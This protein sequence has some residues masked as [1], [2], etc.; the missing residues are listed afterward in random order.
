MKKLLIISLAAM[1][2]V[3]AKAELLEPSVA[4]ER[5]LDEMP[6]GSA[7]RAMRAKTFN[8]LKTVALNS[9][10]AELYVFEAPSSLMVVSAESETAALLG[11]SDNY[12]EGCELPP[13]MVTMLNLYAE[14]I[15]ALRQGNVISATA[16]ADSRADF[17]PIDPICKTQWNQNGPYNDNTPSINGKKTYTGCVATAMAQVLKTYEYPA[18]CSGGSYTYAWTKGGKNLTLNFNTVT[19]RWDDMLDSY[20]G[21]STSSQRSAVAGLMKAI[22][23]ASQMDYGSDASG[24]QSIYC[25]AGLIRNFD[26][27]CTSRF[28]QRDW[29][30]LADWQK[31]I[32]DELA[33]GHP[34]YYDGQ[35]ADGNAGHAFVI[36]GYSSDGFFHVNWGWGGSLDGYFLLTALDPEGQQGIGG[37]SGGYSKGCGAVLGLTPG[38][39]TAE[40]D[41]PLTFSIYGGDLLVSPSQT[42]QGQY[43][44]ISFTN[45]GLLLSFMPFEV[46]N[47][48]VTLKLTSADGKDYYGKFNGPIDNLKTFYG[49]KTMAVYL[50]TGLPAGSYTM[51][52]CVTRQKDNGDDG[53]IYDVYGNQAGKWRKTATVTGNTVKI[54]DY[55]EP[56]TG[57]SA[58]EQ[59]DAADAPVEYFD[60][61]GRRVANPGRGIYIRRQGSNTQTVHIK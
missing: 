36:D 34:V 23:Y 54:S 20:S 17:S 29:F 32:Y 11:Y 6:A 55:V 58:L 45:D 25:L 56:P 5:A 46:S 10:E 50:P 52:L 31:M 28:L 19:L 61:G 40:E 4:L 3:G 43:V 12:F 41:A 8:R 51:Q 7:R 39:T 49:Y 1:A 27:D 13:A 42:T 59:V 47:I 26:Y 9:A 24:T 15:R 38:K 18:K 22:G 14:E 33:A 44:T 60:L 35:N 57:D 37:S 53:V 2:M 30:P 16:S 48:Y 21:T